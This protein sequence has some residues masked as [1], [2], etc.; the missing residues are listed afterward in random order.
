[1]CGRRRSWVR[2]KRRIG[3]VL[4]RADY[5]DQDVRRRVREAGGTRTSRERACRF[6]YEAAIHLV[7]DERIVGF[8]VV[9]DGQKHE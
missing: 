6:D 9:D 5:S 3:R 2:G 7:L 8:L 1:M 4:S